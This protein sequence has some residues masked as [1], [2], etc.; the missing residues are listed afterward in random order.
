MSRMSRTVKATRRNTDKQGNCLMDNQDT[1]KYAAKNK[2]T[3]L[4]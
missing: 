4:I 3:R 2:P 1:K